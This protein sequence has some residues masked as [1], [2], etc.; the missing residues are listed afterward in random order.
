MRFI[1]KLI[2]VIGLC[3]ICLSL[4]GCNESIGGNEVEWEMGGGTAL[5]SFYA[6][7][8]RFDNNLVW[9]HTNWTEWWHYNGRDIVFIYSEEEAVAVGHPL[10]VIVGWPSAYSRSF[11]AGINHYA[12]EID[13]ERFELSYPLTLSDL[14]DHWEAIDDMLAHYNTVRPSTD[15]IVRIEQYAVDNFSAEDNE[16]L[17]MRL[18]LFPGRLDTFNELIKDRDISQVDLTWLNENREIPFTFDDLPTWPITE[19]DVHNSSVLVEE[20]FMTLL[21]GEEFNS[22]RP[23]ALLRAEWWMSNGRLDMLNGYIE[24]RDITTVD[25]SRLNRPAFTG[26][27]PTWPITEED[28]RRSPRV[29]N[30]ISYDLLTAS[31]FRRI[32]EAEED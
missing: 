29:I 6:R 20:I 4:T 25:T 23:E 24:N 2:T 15:L 11:V 10:D 28:V 3:L 21:T 26:E 32:H 5:K 8:L 27:L 7:R 12:D 22:I 13:F 17:W 1:R 31:E 16:R 18:W 30:A 19:D 14:V 9:R